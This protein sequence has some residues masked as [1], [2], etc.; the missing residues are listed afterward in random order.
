A[1]NSPTVPAP[2]APPAN[3]AARAAAKLQGYLMEQQKQAQAALSKT[4]PRPNSPWDGFYV[5][6]PILAVLVVWHLRRRHI[7]LSPPPPLPRGAPGA[8]AALATARGP[9]S[10]GQFVR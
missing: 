8:L 2:E 6:L 7:Y 10:G 4:T 5:A 3:A 1:Q 9:S